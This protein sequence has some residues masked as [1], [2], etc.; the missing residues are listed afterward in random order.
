MPTV[1]YCSWMPVDGGRL[2]DVV[3]GKMADGWRWPMG[4]GSLTGG[5]KADRGEMRTVG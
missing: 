5:K 1:G 3:T 4:G 2:E